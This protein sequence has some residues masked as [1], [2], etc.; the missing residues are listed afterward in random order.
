MTSTRKLLTLLTV[1]ALLLGAVTVATAQDA[2]D[3]VIGVMLPTENGDFYDGMIEALESAAADMGVTLSIMAAEYDLETEAEN[4]AELAEAGI[5]AL[6]LRPV[7]AVESMAVIAEAN[8][9]GIPVFIMGDDAEL[10]AAEV[11]VVSVVGLDNRAGGEAAADYMCEQIDVEGTV[12]EIVVSYEVDED[13][14]EPAMAAV[15]AARQA[16]F[17]EA[18]ASCAGLTIETLDVTG[19]NA[20][21][22]GSAV[23][24]VLADGDVVGVVAHNDSHILAVVRPVMRAG[25]SVVLVGFNATEDTLG[26]ITLGRLQGIV[27]ASG[28]ELGVLT[29]E[30]AV[31]YLNGEEVEPQISLVPHLID[32]SSIGAVR[33]MDNDNCQD[34]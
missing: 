16:G 26:A 11:E 29:L 12:L 34:N 20:R 24:D 25:T 1:V 15:Y 27:S 14:A 21:E 28:G 22:I 18:L 6:L 2:E 33:C 32:G 13:E 7:D 4:F 31:A 17:D 30:T 19:M 9:A 5:D 3:A 8:E 10:T 23:A